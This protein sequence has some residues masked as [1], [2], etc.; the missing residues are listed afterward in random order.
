MLLDLSSD[1]EFF[2]DTTARFL[3]EHAS[4]AELRRLRDDDAGFDPSYWRKGA[5]LGWTSLLVDEQHGGGTISGNGLT[6]LTLVAYEFGRRAAPGPLV[7]TNVVAGALSAAGD[8]AHTA[9]VAD[10]L[11]GNAIAAWCLGEPPPHDRVGEIHVRIEVDGGDLVLDGVKRPVESAA[12]ASHLLVTGRTGDGLTQVLVP[13]DTPG[14]SIT[15]MK[16]VDLTRRFFVVAF[17]GVRVPAEATV[18]QVGKAGEDVDRQLQQ[19]L[20]IVNAEAVGALQSA[21]DMTV[22]WA[23]DRYSFGRPLAS[24]Q[25]LKH[26]FARHEDLARGEPRDQRRRCGRR[27]RQA[28]PTPPSWPARRRPTSGTS[29]QSSCTSASSCTVASA[30]PTSTT[31]TS[32]CVGTPSTGRCSARPPSTVGASPIWSW[33][34]RGIR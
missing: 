21:F 2:R 10:L 33:P 31:C 23:F 6:D 29:A 17:D 34:E 11:A 9:V 4:P 32:S 30:S 19:A 25:A 5:D 18:G 7:P 15:P 12:Q 16:S 22:E 27:W 20:A 8:D 24:Y 14:I 28:P 3:H 26:R 13:A 1:Q